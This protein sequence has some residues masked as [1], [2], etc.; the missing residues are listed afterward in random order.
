M[1]LHGGLQV[2]AK[3]AAVVVIDQP[4]VEDPES[5]MPPQPAAQ[6]LCS[7]IIKLTRAKRQKNPQVHNSNFACLQC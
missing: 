3:P 5:L 2:V 7:V 1:L 6:L 4:I